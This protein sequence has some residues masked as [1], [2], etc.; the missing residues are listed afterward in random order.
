MNLSGPTQR[1][2]E[3]NDFS[4]GGPIGLSST[5]GAMGYSK[6]STPKKVCGMQ[7]KNHVILVSGEL[8]CAV[9]LTSNLSVHTC[10][11]TS[12][13]KTTHMCVHMYTRAL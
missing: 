4:P 7:C 13:S 5:G 11:L 12:D 3:Y 10:P 8:Q 2:T 9:P 1:V 6:T